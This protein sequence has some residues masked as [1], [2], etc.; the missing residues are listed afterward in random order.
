MLVDFSG[1][2]IELADQ[3][4][5]RG[6]AIPPP[7]VGPGADH[8]HRVDDAAH[9]REYGGDMQRSRAVVPPLPCSGFR[10]PGAAHGCPAGVTPRRSAV[11]STVRAGAAL[12]G[13]LSSPPPQRR[14]ASCATDTSGA[15][16]AGR[17]AERQRAA[18]AV[19]SRRGSTRGAACRRPYRHFSRRPRPI[20]ELGGRAK[21]G[22]DCGERVRSA[23]ERRL[24]PLRQA[25]PRVD[26]RS[27]GAST[28]FGSRS[29]QVGSRLARGMTREPG[30]SAESSRHGIG[31]A[32][33]NAR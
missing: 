15:V 27:T 22:D 17:V 8:V 7:A 12:A 25:V 2:A 16:G 31:N 4:L 3:A 6:R 26:W 11:R 9:G 21:R 14:F 19:A 23:A 28:R 18:S 30:G 20:T 5:D 24:Q 32:D 10:I 33:R 13:T 1:P 29:E